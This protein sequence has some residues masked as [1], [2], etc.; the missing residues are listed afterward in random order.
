VS[1]H[2][3]ETSLSHSVWRCTQGDVTLGWDFSTNAPGTKFARVKEQAGKPCTKIFELPNYMAPEQRV[4]RALADRK[5]AA[6]RER[7]AHAKLIE[8]YG[9]EGA[10]ELAYIEELKA[11]RG[12]PAPLK[13]RKYRLSRADKQAVLDLPDI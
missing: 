5:E 3:G 13:L 11:R 8:I 12:P 4:E 1:L 10:A 2:H 6:E 9:E 7:Q